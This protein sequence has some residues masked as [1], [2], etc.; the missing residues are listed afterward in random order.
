MNT[1]TKNV[2]NRFLI[3]PALVTEA[4]NSQDAPRKLANLA[5]KHFASFSLT[6]LDKVDWLSL[7]K[8]LRVEWNSGYHHSPPMKTAQPNRL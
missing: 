7:A 8:R 2:Y 1:Q 6:T 5:G 4:M 3:A